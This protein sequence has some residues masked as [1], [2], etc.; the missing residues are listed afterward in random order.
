[1]ETFENITQE[2]IDYLIKKANGID[3]AVLAMLVEIRRGQQG[4]FYVKLL[5]KLEAIKENNPIVTYDNLNAYIAEITEKV[6]N[7]KQKRNRD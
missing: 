7:V 6:N 5:K 1:V 4:Q 2:D 3:A